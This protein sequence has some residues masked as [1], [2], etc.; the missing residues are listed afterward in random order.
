M[1]WNT[2]SST[3]EAGLLYIVR[4]DGKVQTVPVML[5]Y[6]DS[7]EPGMAPLTLKRFSYACQL[8]AAGIDWDEDSNACKKVEDLPDWYGDDLPVEPNV[9]IWVKGTIPVFTT[10]GVMQMSVN[11][12]TELTSVRNFVYIM[13]LKA[14]ERQSITDILEEHKPATPEY[15][16]PEHNELDE[17]FPRDENGQAPTTAPQAPAP[18]P[19]APHALSDG[20]PDGVINLVNYDYKLK[21]QYEAECAGKVV[22]FNVSQ[23]KR[24]MQAKKDGTGAYECLHIF[25][26]HDGLPADKH[27]IYDFTTF[28]LKEGQ[29]FGDWK[30]FFE[31]ITDG[32]LSELGSSIT[33]PM[34]FY[35]K[36]S[37]SKDGNKI[38]WNLRRV[39]F[40]GQTAPA[41]P[42]TQQMMA[43]TPRDQDVPF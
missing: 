11:V 33:Q 22:C 7:V 43:G 8:L 12:F 41:Q 42:A 4:D 1:I 6:R 21:P 5:V 28:P 27:P 24:L 38:F 20:I 29:N 18:L 15:V 23:V 13:R 34:R 9:Q 26:Y 36:L 31:A 3:D 17:Y 35:Y 19:P 30:T 37:P 39:E 40:L 16:E 2:V 14:E 32:Q 25:G 10:T